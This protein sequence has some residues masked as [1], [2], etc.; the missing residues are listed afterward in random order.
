MGTEEMQTYQANVDKLYKD[1]TNCERKWFKGSLRKKLMMEES[2]TA[3]DVSQASKLQKPRSKDE[4][5]LSSTMK[6]FFAKMAA[7]K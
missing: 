6:E 4:G 7:L 3:D 1:V 5:H 2:I